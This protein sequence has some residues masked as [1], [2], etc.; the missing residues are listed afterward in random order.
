MDY[1]KTPY[2]NGNTY[3]S[4]R[5]SGMATASLVL[6]IVSLISSSCIYL[7]MPCGALGVILALLSR[8]GTRSMDTQAAA[9]LVL[10]ACGLTFTILFVV[11][12]VFVMY[13]T[14]GGWDGIL[15]EYMTLYGV[16]TVEELYQ[17]FGIY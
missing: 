10:S 11:F 13:Q 16:D 5:S 4:R 2:S 3:K 12:G 14:F 8:G 9:G 6:G 17:I 7:A 15:R 1:N